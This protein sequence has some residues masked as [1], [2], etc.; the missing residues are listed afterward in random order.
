MFARIAV[1]VVALVFV[2]IGAHSISPRELYHEMYPLAPVERDAFHIC[3]EADPT[4]VRAVGAD[5]EACYDSMPHIM[6]LAMGRVKPGRALSLQ[7]LSDPSREAELLMTLAAMP[8]R[9]P[10]TSPRSF[11]D[12]AWLHA[13][14]APCAARFSAPAVVYAIPDGLPP[15]AGSGRAAALASVAGDSLPPLKPRPIQASTA[16]RDP[17]PVIS[18]AGSDTGLAPTSPDAGLDDRAAL[19]SQLPAPD[20]G[21]EAPPAIVPLAPVSACGGA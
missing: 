18:L 10:I 5:R 17:L 2:A 1:A 21:D 8:P 7:A 14:A 12:T 3:D 20:I 11:T 16:H 13:L 6:A 4:F 15:P 19:L 9:Q